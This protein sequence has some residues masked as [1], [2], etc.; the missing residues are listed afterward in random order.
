MSN[1]LEKNFGRR[2]VIFD[3]ASGTEFYRR[4]IFVNN[5]Y[6]NL[7][8]SMPEAVKKLH[9]EYLAAGSEVLTTNTFGANANKLSRYG[10]G[11]RVAEI[12]AAAVRLA[13]EAIAESGLDAA[14][15]N[16]PRRALIAGSVGPVGGITG[17]GG[18]L[19]REKAAAILAGQMT[20]LLE[21][22]ADF[23]LGE[24]I[25]TL[26]DAANFAAALELSKVRESAASFALNSDLTDANGEYAAKYLKLFERLPATLRPFAFGLNCGM[27][28]DEMLEAMKRLRGLAGEKG[29]IIQPNSGSPH[30]VDDRSMYMCTPEYFTTYARRFVELGAIGVGGCCGTSPEHIAEMAKAVRPLENSRKN[31]VELLNRTEEKTAAPMPE[32]PFEKRSRLAEKL[33]AGEF[34]RTVE[35]TPP[36]G[37]DLAGVLAKARSCAEAGIDAVNIP[38]GPRASSRIS[39]AAT[40]LAVQREVKIETV[41]HVCARDRNVIALQSDLLGYAALGL[42]NILFITG[43]PPKLG[44]YSFAS[45]VF[46][47]D[48]VGMLEMASSLNRGLDI[49]G[50]SI[51]RPTSIC[52]GCGA[53]PSAVDMARE[54]RRLEEKAAAGARFVVTQPV[55][56][57]E[58]LLRMIEKA[59]HLDLPFIAGIWPLASLKNAEFMK[60]QVP[61]VI[62]PDAVMEK[63]ARY[64]NREDQARAGV[65][66]AR[67]TAAALEGYIAG[68]QVSAPLGKVE[69]A[70]AVHAR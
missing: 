5:C 24:S 42:N 37:F 61:G 19:E 64:P 63:M 2:A 48:S 13:K 52:P 27:G 14:S 29:L 43:D 51:R 26:D 25:A 8:L 53:D 65:E 22:G 6:E 47:L 1:I 20:V 23:I 34:V 57:V 68:M 59:A 66:I 4:G 33:A 7:C 10:L 18:R 67:D 32:V 16:A 30:R 38:D 15:E 45:G 3:G 40:A 9:L 62:V 39:A 50:K 17:H 31:V 44:D 49:T 28:P 35:I 41:L 58:P 70:L 55:F 54:M 36:P 69:I 12:N 21:A 60:T 46:D 56:A 11:E